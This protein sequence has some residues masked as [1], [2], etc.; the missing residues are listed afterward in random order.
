MDDRQSSEQAP[1]GSSTTTMVTS[2]GSSCMNGGMSALMKMKNE[3]LLTPRMALTAASTKQRKH[4]RRA[5][6]K[7]ITM[8]VC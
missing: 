6:S 1:H 5:T 8:I 7:S 2:T 4:T 3:V